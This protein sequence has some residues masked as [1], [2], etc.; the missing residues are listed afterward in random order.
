MRPARLGGRPSTLHA[1][2][3]WPWATGSNGRG[4]LPRR[5]RRRAPAASGLPARTSSCRRS[6]SWRSPLLLQ[7]AGHDGQVLLAEPLVNSPLPFAGQDGQDG[8]P[9]AARRLQR[10]VHV[11]DRQRQRELGRELAVGDPLQLGSL[12]RRHQ[13]AAAQRVRHR[14]GLKA[15]PVSESNRRGN[16]FGR[17]RQPGVV[18]QLQPRSG[19]GRADPDRAL[20]S[21]SNSGAARARASPG[22]DAKIVSWPR[23]AGSLL[24]DTGASRK[25]TSGRSLPTMAATRSVP[26]TPIVLIWAQIA[27]GARAASM[28]WSRATEMTAS[29][30]VTIVTTTAA[31]RAA[32][33]A[34]PAS[35]ATGSCVP[36]IGYPLTGDC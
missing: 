15:Q 24:P 13:R 7:Q 21:A 8:E 2:G 1:Y 10:E 14:P 32:P 20:P 12:P 9:A 33:A 18:H 34:V 25:I 5:G 23:S 31:R 16:R 28:P 11:L 36:A 22:P 4:P 30:S 27:P 6:G 3:E 17:E 29:A 19:P 26:A 35:T